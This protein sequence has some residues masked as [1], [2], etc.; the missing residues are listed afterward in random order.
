LWEIF[1]SESTQQSFQS[2]EARA[3]GNVTS[4]QFRYS[5][6]LTE[7]FYLIFSKYSISTLLAAF[8]SILPKVG[9]FFLK[10]LSA[11]SNIFLHFLK[12]DISSS[13]NPIL[14]L[15][16]LSMSCNIFLALTKLSA[17]FRRVFLLKAFS[18]KL[19]FS[20]TSFRRLIR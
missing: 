20:S 1:K 8:I 12:A 15:R 13:F 19:R 5:F 9:L 4:T 10:C 11:L 16:F 2:R 3:L 14:S 7:F 17:H 6:F 18:L